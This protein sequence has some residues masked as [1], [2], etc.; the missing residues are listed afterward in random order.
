MPR[1]YIKKKRNVIQKTPWGYSRIF[2]NNLIGLGK[3]SIVDDEV[4]KLFESGKNVTADFRQNHVDLDPCITVEGKK[5]RLY[6]YLMKTDT[7][8]GQ[9]CDHINHQT[10]DCRKCNLRNGTPTQ[11]KAN[12]RRGVGKVKRINGGRYV[13]VFP[14]NIVH[15]ISKFIFDSKVDAEMKLKELQVELFGDFSYEKSQK[16]AKEIETYEFVRQWRV[17]YWAR[18]GTMGKIYRLPP[19][20]PLNARLRDLI[21]LIKS[22]RIEPDE[23][24]KL[25]HELMYDYH[26]FQ[27]KSKV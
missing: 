23:E 19:E 9:Q 1:K 27:K 24:W 26:I 7:S 20:N 10:L 3:Y 17:D 13:I 2:F 14:K 5:T 11:N 18:T 15:D 4:V 25:Q 21:V 22:G 6:N 8:S 12:M 16:I